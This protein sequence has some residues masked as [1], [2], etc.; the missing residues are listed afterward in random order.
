MIVY[1]DTSSLVKLYVQEAHTASVK[2]WVDEAEII[3]TCRIAYPETMSA[4]SRRFREG[5]LSE[6][7]YNLLTDKFSNEW[8][9]FAVVDFDE[10]E[11]GRLVNLY[12]LRGFDAVH[13][14]AASL[15][16]ANQNNISL[17]FSSFD[18]KLNDAASSEGLL[19]L[20]L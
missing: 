12:G 19:I 9:R 5:D 18:K 11:A 1:F 10:L 13:L 8:E 6:K 4:I 16:K 2:K 7:Q 17:S 14:S 3:A 20:S 15:L